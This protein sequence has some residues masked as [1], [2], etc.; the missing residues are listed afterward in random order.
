MFADNTRGCKGPGGGCPAEAQLRR[1]RCC[2][3]SRVPALPP[4]A[5]SPEEP[6]GSRA[7]TPAVLIPQCQLPLFPVLSAHN[8]SHLFPPSPRLLAEV[9]APSSPSCLGC[10]S[11]LY[12]VSLPP[13]LSLS[14]VPYT[15]QFFSHGNP[16]TI[17]AVWW[18]LNS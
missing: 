1:A 13:V 14:S 7:Q 18:S 12:M 3:P 10:G 5:G 11:R 17:K 6:G 9:P 15:E 4:R 2:R 16:T 8:T